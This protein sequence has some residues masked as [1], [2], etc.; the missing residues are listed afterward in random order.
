LPERDTAELLKTIRK[1]LK[2]E[3]LASLA[4][5]VIEK[6]SR[7]E[8]RLLGHSVPDDE[9]W[10]WIQKFEPSEEELTLQ[11]VRWREFSRKPLVSVIVPVWKPV[12][13]I[14]R[15]MISSVLAQTYANWEL[16]LADGGSDQSIKTVLEEYE[17]DSRVHIRHLTRNLGISGNSNAALELADGEFIALM[18]QDDLLS[19]SALFEVVRCIND[20]LEAD[21]LYSDMDKVDSDG[22][23]FD[24][25]FKPDWSPE[26]MFCT[27]YVTHLSVI[28]ASLL[29]RL[30]GLRS[31]TDGAQDWD[32][33]LRASEESA[34]FVH[35]PKILYHWRQA[36]TSVAKA[37]VRISVLVSKET[38]LTLT[39]H[40]S[41]SNMQGSVYL[42]RGRWRVRWA[43][44]QRI[45]VIIR[46]AGDGLSLNRCINSVLH[47]STYKNYEIVI[48][49]PS[50]VP[51]E[52]PTDPRIVTLE[53]QDYS[54]PAHVNNLA[55]R[56]SSGQVL[57]FLDPHTEI[58][59]KPW[60]E[61]L[62]GWASQKQIGAVGA[63][64]L[65]TNRKHIIH[66]GI[67]MGLPDYLMNGARSGVW[68]PLGHSDW[69]RNCT[70]V[71]GA[72]MAI[73]REL[74]HQLGEF[75]DRLGDSWDIGF[76]LTAR[77]HGFRILYTPVAELT[78]EQEHRNLAKFPQIEE[79]RKILPPRDQYFNP[80]LSYENPIPRLG[81]ELSPKA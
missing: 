23:R 31:S 27:N 52:M 42:D 81:W 18:D 77:T 54:N 16:C 79:Y 53:Y 5:Q 36:P 80:N 2:Q 17:S 34:C 70:A 11:K 50:E 44:Q 74:F 51:V 38:R 49:K 61:E 13:H 41:R 60:L 8:F 35:V 20:R 55:A 28:R 66:A 33:V 14:L 69:Y 65:T 32:L 47:N 58:I 7:R 1:T 48:A 24:P 72:C 43:P 21:Y 56:I 78:F 10:R 67:V 6:I 19:P 62:S 15:S 12:E 3:G 45:S 64:L 40:L 73:R 46:F 71:S 9:Y 59:S 30:E 25:F 57:V 37:G 63:K 39:D 26:I 76:C 22:N 4:T 75:D 29:R 68:T